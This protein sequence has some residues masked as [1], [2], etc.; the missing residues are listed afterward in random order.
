MARRQP[1][2]A[3]LVGTLLLGA[4][5]AAPPQLVRDE[6][7]LFSEDARQ[8]AEDRLRTVAVDSGVWVFVV[9]D[10]AADPPRMLDA[11]MSEANRAGVSAYAV[12]FGPERIVG[13]GQSERGSDAFASVD[14][15][16]ADEAFRAGTPD[17]ALRLVVDRV[18]D[19]V[20]RGMPNDAENAP[21]MHPGPS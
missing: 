4:C 8:R 5:S 18:V 13:S 10:A 21:P 15:L 9:S 12:L 19:W 14:L 3:A 7:G 1:L 20:N 16:A 11:P 2:A 17:E 6:L